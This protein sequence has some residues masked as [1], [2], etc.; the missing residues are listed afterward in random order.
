MHKPYGSAWIVYQA[1]RDAVASTLDNWLSDSISQ[2]PAIT[3]RLATRIADNINGQ[4]YRGISFTSISIPD[5]G[6]GALEHDLGADLAG[7][8]NVRVPG[9]SSSKLF[10][11]Q[12][13]I[14]PGRRLDRK[15]LH[16]LEDQCSKMLRVTPHSV[17]F[18]YSEEGV[19][20]VRARDALQAVKE[21]LARPRGGI[22]ANEMLYRKRLDHYLR[23]VY[24]TWQGDEERGRT[25]STIDDLETVVADNRA[26]MGLAI[27][28]TAE[29]EPTP[30]RP[31][32]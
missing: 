14:A 24:M 6:P 5:R 29:T 16:D 1:V 22:D 11:A 19:D 15:A 23:E 20:V 17:V 27:I 21:I 10:L 25:V 32:G 3:E 4:S 2:E 28:A 31:S 26:R 18:L 13:K 9:Y 30:S 12:G 8:L 7:V